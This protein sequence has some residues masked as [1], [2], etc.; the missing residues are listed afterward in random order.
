METLGL[1]RYRH[2]RKTSPLLLCL[3]ALSCSSRPG[4]EDTVSWQVSPLRATE[5]VDDLAPYVSELEVFPVGS[6]G[7]ARPG[8]SKILF[9][10]PIVFLSGGVAFSASPD[11]K[12]VKQIGNIGRGPAEY[13][14]VKD[15]MINA[16]G[17]EL[18]CMDVLNSILRYDLSTMSFMGK[19]ECEKKGY[20][21]AMIPLENNGVALYTPNPPGAFPEKHE[22]FYCLSYYTAS[23]KTVDQ[24]LP[25]TQFNVMAGF[26]NPVSTAAPNTSILIPE[27]SNIAYVFENNGLDHQ[28]I[29]DFGNKWIP[30]NFINPKDG[31]HARKVGDL[32]DL[33]CFKL[34]SSVFFPAGDLYFHAFGKESSSW[35]FFISKD[36]TNGIRWRSVGGMAPPISA[37]ASRDEYL[38]FMYDD[39]GYAEE[40]QDPL[41]RLVI[42]KY[43]LPV[44]I[45]STYLIKVRFDV[46]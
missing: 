19:V 23:G 35:N 10:D 24:W 30:L 31:D 18:W 7:I 1:V 8:I 20:A 5:E 32:F 2:S 25:W 16:A 11:W 14:S 33:D 39:Y 13:L 12:T 36:G 37:I 4:V 29:F 43:G 46:G 27:S 3:I 21:R 22:T 41:K 6:D 15:I 9:S 40:E 44:E 28:I 26:S 42:E 34:I 45:G 38:Y 17:D